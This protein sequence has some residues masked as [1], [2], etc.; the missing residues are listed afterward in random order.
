MYRFNYIKR[1]D[2]F[3]LQD[4]MSNCRIAYKEEDGTVTVIGNDKLC[5]NYDISNEVV[6]HIITEKEPFRGWGGTI[7]LSEC[8]ELY[9]IPKTYC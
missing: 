8:K 7:F 1:G 6:T 5:K 3:Q 4:C 9:K 2:F